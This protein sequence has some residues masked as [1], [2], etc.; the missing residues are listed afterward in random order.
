MCYF[1][2]CRAVLKVCHDNSYYPMFFSGTDEQEIYIILCPHK[3]V[4]TFFL[5]ISY[6]ELDDTFFITSYVELVSRHFGTQ[7]FRTTIF[8]KFVLISLQS[9]EL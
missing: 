6:V 3:Y 8:N 4:I 7:T 2:L 5:I 1:L 9:T